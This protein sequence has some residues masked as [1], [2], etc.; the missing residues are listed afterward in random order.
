MLKQRLL[1]LFVE[2][3]YL[4]EKEQNTV[5]GNE[6]VELGDYL[7]DIARARRRAVQAHEVAVGLLCDYARQSGLA[8]TGRAV[9]DH[10]RQLAG[11]DYIA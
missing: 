4:V 1:L 10:V 11:F 7:L 9:K 6:G 3:L 2:I 5:A 8:D